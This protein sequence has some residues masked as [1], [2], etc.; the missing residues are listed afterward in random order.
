MTRG[1]TCIKVAQSAITVACQFTFVL[2][3][4]SSVENV[5]P[6]SLIFFIFGLVITFSMLMLSI[7]EAIMRSR[8]LLQLAARMQRAE[9]V[10]AIRA[11]RR[12]SAINPAI[13]VSAAF[14]GSP[15]QERIPEATCDCLTNVYCTLKGQRAKGKGQ[16]RL[17]KYSGH[18]FVC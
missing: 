10:V 12:A 1:C 18:F 14:T 13:N 17:L 6:S 15:L 3:V 2:T 9:Q 4:N 8:M 16:R 7:Y 11:I 5:S